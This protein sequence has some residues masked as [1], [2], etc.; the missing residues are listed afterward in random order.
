MAVSRAMLSVECDAEG[1]LVAAPSVDAVTKPASA[2]ASHSTAAPLGISV[3]TGASVVP[4]EACRRSHAMYS[5]IAVFRGVGRHPNSASMGAVSS[6][7]AWS[8][9]SAERVRT[10]A[11]AAS[12]SDLLTRL[13][14]RAVSKLGDCSRWSSGSSS[15][16]A[17]SSPDEGGHPHAIRGAITEVPMEKLT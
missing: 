15:A 9:W 17:R 16:A 12:A 1:A 8:Q 14:P 6:G 2:A 10:W 7:R 13:M 3:V 4:G 5:A 11:T